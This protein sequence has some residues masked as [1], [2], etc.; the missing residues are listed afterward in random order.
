[1]YLLE[2]IYIYIFS[3]VIIVGLAEILVTTAELF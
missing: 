3:V 2:S 1:M